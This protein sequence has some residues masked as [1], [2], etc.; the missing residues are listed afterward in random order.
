MAH[1]NIFKGDAFSAM[2][3]GEAIRVIPNQ[4]G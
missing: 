4:W 3:L 1:I 2:A